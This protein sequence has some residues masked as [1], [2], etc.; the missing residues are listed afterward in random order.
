LPSSGQRRLAI[1]FTRQEERKGAAIMT[2]GDLLTNFRS[3]I[4]GG[5]IK[6]V[7]WGTYAG[8][9]FLPEIQSW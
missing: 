7:R 2:Q 3:A 5:P 8:G 6:D 9:E 4:K 1:S